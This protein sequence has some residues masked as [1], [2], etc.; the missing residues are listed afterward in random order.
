MQKGTVCVWQRFK[1]CPK[2]RG[3]IQLSLPAGDVTAKNW[4]EWSIRSFSVSP[5]LSLHLWNWYRSLYALWSRISMFQVVERNCSQTYP[6]TVKI[7][8]LVATLKSFQLWYLDEAVLWVKRLVPRRFIQLVSIMHHG[9]GTVLS[10][11]VYPTRFIYGLVASACF[12]TSLFLLYFFNPCFIL[13]S[14]LLLQLS[15]LCLLKLQKFAILFC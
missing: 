3:S 4:A 14:A 12:N 13:S 8:Q 5:I 15:F 11:S 6:I 10:N 7:S 1:G 9:L 2:S